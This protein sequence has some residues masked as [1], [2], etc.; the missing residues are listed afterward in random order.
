MLGSV[1]IFKQA[2][3]TDIKFWCN[4]LDLRALIIDMGQLEYITPGQTH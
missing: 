4:G 3:I 1:F 2:F